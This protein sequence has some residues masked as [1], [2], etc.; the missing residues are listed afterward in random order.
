[1]I[2]LVR[3]TVGID[4]SDYRDTELL[5]LGDGNLLPLWVDYEQSCGKLLHILDSAEILLN[6]LNLEGELSDLLLVKTLKGAVFSH[7]VELLKT[8]Y[9]CLNGLKVCHHA[10]YPSGVDIV[11]VSSQC[12]L[13]DGIACLLLCSYEQNLSALA[14]DLSD[15]GV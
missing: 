8:G 7:L 9:S 13:P 2:N 5:C 15:N 6:L 3:V 12:L 10:A 14:G 1:I 11:S 4:Y